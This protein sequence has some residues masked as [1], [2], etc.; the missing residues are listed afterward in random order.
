[1]A[2]PNGAGTAALI[3]SAHPT[4]TRDQVVAQMLG[5]GDNIDAQNPSRVGLLGGGRVNPYNALTM[6]LDNPQVQTVTDLPGDGVY[7]D[8]TTIDRFSVKF[9]QVMDPAS[10]NA[11]GAFVLRSAGVD[12]MFGTADDTVYTLDTNPYMIGTNQL[13]FNIA[14]GPLNYGHYQLVISAS[15]QN[16]FMDAL[17]GDGDG[18]GG[19][20]YVQEFFISPPPEGVVTL[21]RSSYLV[22]DTILISV[23]DANAVGP[24]SVDVTT[25][26]GDSETVVLTD[27]GFGRFEGSI[28]TLAGSVVTG[29]G[30]LEVSLG[31]II[32]V[33]YNDLDDGTGNSSTSVDTA[34]I[35]NVIRFDAADTPLAI[36]DNS[37]TTSVIPISFN[38]SVADL[39]LLLDITHTYDGDLSA[40]LTSP[41]GV[42]V[43]LFNRIGGSGN[44]YTQTYFDDEAANSINSGSPP[45]TGNFR[46]LG[47]FSNFDNGSVQGNWTLRV[48]DSAGLD[49]GSLNSW[50]LFIDVI[51]NEPNISISS[52]TAITEGDDGSTTVDFVVSLSSTSGS[53]VEVDYTTTTA[54][55]ANPATPGID[56]EA[57]ADTL[58]FQPGQQSKTISVTVYGDRFKELDEEFGIVLSNASGGNISA[59]NG[60]VLI[61][62]NDDFALG[63]T[64][65]FG[66]QDSVVDGSSIGFVVDAYSPALGMG[67][68]NATGLTTGTQQRGNDLTRD[69]AVAENA[70]FVIDVANGNY[71]VTVFVGIVGRLEPFD[72][73]IE[74]TE[75]RMRPSPGPNVY[76]TFAVE[77]LDGQINVQM[78]GGAGFDNTA[79]ISGLVVNQVGGRPSDS[80]GIKNSIAAPRQANVPS[81]FGGSGPYIA[82]DPIQIINPQLPSS[83]TDT[84]AFYSGG[85]GGLR[86]EAPTIE[87][88]VNGE[89]HCP[90]VADQPIQII[91]GSRADTTKFYNASLRNSP[92]GASLDESV[93][94]DWM[95]DLAEELFN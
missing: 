69:Y 23:G 15:T 14:E 3:W 94:I 41:S 70:E 24:I 6:T 1:M 60:S 30:M 2:A 26:A 46:P 84:T 56:F 16:P 71:E 76:R 44:N 74:G 86:F 62:D 68:Q 64:I 17:D 75:Y 33:T 85:G 39:D 19:D 59:G 10:I 34:D 43:T 37:T 7:L 53:P 38:G 54:G 32:T 35:S 82:I 5:T 66:P 92:D 61:N 45:F 55:F 31:N 29:N 8:D 65:D 49:Q 47:S 78:D 25:N 67:W 93:K 72:L 91:N 57:A 4:W 50:S 52:P 22:N 95:N 63:T 83:R 77:I 36:T 58:V 12:D 9:N 13:R 87:E 11:A 21:D 90:Y 88:V 48:T 89:P 18:N 28:N 51:P 79:R 27:A 20:A 42:Q 80:G 81:L 40:T 73:T